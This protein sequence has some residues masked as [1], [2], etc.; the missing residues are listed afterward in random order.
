MNFDTRDLTSLYS[1][2]TSA[3]RL[4]AVLNRLTAVGRDSFK[5]ISLSRMNSLASLTDL[6]GE[7]EECV[8]RTWTS[9]ASDNA[10]TI[11]IAGANRYLNETEIKPPR[12]FIVLITLKPSSESLTSSYTLSNGSNN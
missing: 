5:R 7:W 10:A 6:K 11:A 3:A 12:T 2:L 1:C 9:T 8:C 4:S